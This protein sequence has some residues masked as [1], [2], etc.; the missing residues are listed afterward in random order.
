M[1]YYLSHFTEDTSDVPH[2]RH[3]PRRLYIR[4]H[5]P[6]CFMY[7]PPVDPIHIKTSPYY[8]RNK[9]VSTRLHVYLRLG[10]MNHQKNWLDYQSPSN[11]QA[12]NANC[13]TLTQCIVFA[14]STQSSNDNTSFF[15]K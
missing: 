3:N 5:P 7:I 6:I 13:I 10:S 15:V 1:C 2:S 14:I 8:L 4:L 12:N 9:K 11:L